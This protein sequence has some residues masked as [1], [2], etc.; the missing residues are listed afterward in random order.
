MILLFI[1]GALLGSFYNVC[2]YRIPLGISIANPPSHC[3]R[4]GSGVR[5]FDNIPLVSYWLLRGRCRRCGA[6]FSMRYFW[7]ELLT[8]VLFVVT[9]AAI[10]FSLTLLPALVFLS[11]LLIAT[12]TDIDHWIIPDRI[13]LGG[14]VAG[15]VFA[16]IP[17]IAGAPGNPL[18]ADPI[19]IALWPRLG[20][21]WQA[22]VAALIGAIVGYLALWVIGVIGT[23]IF[24]KDAMGMGDMKLMA[25]FGAFCG[26]ERLVYIL[27]IASL[28]GT[29][30]GLAGI[31]AARRERNKPAN[32]PQAMSEEAVAECLTGTELYEPERAL[33][34]HLLRSPAPPAKARHHL[35]FG[36]SLAI[37][38]WLVYLFGA[39]IAARLQSF[40]YG[41]PYE[42]LIV[43]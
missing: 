16:C 1:Y 22:P 7:V 13:S 2:I 38:A 32:A 12:F 10:G 33:A 30:I 19:I 8:A 18:V 36:P 3:Y 37:A 9:G 43:R 39:Q 40:L 23:I 24:R 6:P 34:T 11:L 28:I 29:L 27:L 15:L 14:A 17:P 42:D 20:A 35:P 26:P 31:L 25:T 4:C 21:P 5:W 41:I